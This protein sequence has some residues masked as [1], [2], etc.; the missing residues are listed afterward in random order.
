MKR[1][2][3]RPA[4]TGRQ[5]FETRAIGCAKVPGIGDSNF[6]GPVWFDATGNQNGCR[7]SDPATES[8]SS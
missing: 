5:E 6:C 8:R 7:M 2:Y 4:I 1:E 3:V